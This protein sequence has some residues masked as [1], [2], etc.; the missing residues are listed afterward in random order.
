MINSCIINTFDNLI[1]VSEMMTIAIA[2]Y[3][4]GGIMKKIIA[5]VFLFVSVSGYSLDEKQ[6]R[7]WERT[8]WRLNITLK[9]DKVYGGVVQFAIMES[10][11][12]AA[13]KKD[14]RKIKELS[15]KEN[16]YD[17]ESELSITSVAWDVQFK[18]VS[19]EEVYLLLKGDTNGFS[20]NKPDR[21]YYLVTKTAM[22]DDKPSVW[23]IPVKVKTGE[24]IQVS[25]DDRNAV[26]LYELVK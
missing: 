9:S 10:D 4:M 3:F 20:S 1:S 12:R 5:A 2:G 25:L 14:Y 16:R 23:F 18:E 21:L 6:I 15:I 7:E 11:P 26:N 17:A 24:E 8:T 13:F 19:G 22:I